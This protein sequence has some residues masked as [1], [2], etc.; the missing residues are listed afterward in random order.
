MGTGSLT[1]LPPALGG[2]EARWAT[3]RPAREHAGLDWERQR[4]HIDPALSDVP[5]EK[6]V[7]GFLLDPVLVDAGGEPAIPYANV[8]GVVAYS[9]G[10][11]FQVGLPIVQV[12]GCL[13]L[14]RIYGTAADSG[15]VPMRAAARRPGTEAVP[16]Q[17][18][19]VDGR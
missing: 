5:V 7:A 18:A 8:A 15:A 19:P 2:G 9:G 11:L 10:Q 3:G 16:C 1:G 12:S 17:S 14:G 4:G 6:F 13:P